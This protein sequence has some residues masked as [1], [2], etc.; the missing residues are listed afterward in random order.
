MSEFSNSFHALGLDEEGA[1]Q[2][3]CDARATGLV[4]PKKGKLTT[5]IVARRNWEAVI[6][7]SKG[8]LLLYELAVDHG[9]SLR[10][11]EGPKPSGHLAKSFATGQKLFDAAPFLAAGLLT[12]AGAKELDALLAGR[13]IDRAGREKVA[14][15][16]GLH[17]V[18]DIGSDDLA[19]RKSLLVTTYPKAIFVERGTRAAWEIDLAEQSVIL[20]ALSAKRLA[21]LKEEPGLAADLL[22]ARH[23]QT[24]KGLLD[25]G[26]RGAALVK[27][28][29]RSDAA[30]VVADAV[31]GRSGAVL[32]GLPEGMTAR[33]ISS[34]EVVRI[35]NALDAQSETLVKDR[36]A[37]AGAALG[38]PKLGHGYK[39]MRELYRKA[40]TSGESMLVAFE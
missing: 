25:L 38:E 6:D 27:A 8:T 22:E 40:A 7:K 29:T 4:L 15:L 17:D 32:E 3:L 28:F 24:I 14:S 23:E 37:A 19:E 13:T 30:E 31:R 5:M 26:S 36:C 35:A 33:V 1:A 18:A 16:L 12:K 9:V 10:L 11:F 21:Q 39:A 20:C 34:E 2:L